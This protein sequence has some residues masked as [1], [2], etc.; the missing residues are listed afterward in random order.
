MKR[1]LISAVALILCATMFLFCGCKPKSNDETTVPP[2]TDAAIDN[3]I[4]DDTEP[5]ADDTTQSAQP[6]QP[7]RPAQQVLPTRP[8]SKKP[9]ATKKDPSASV[10]KPASGTSKPNTTVPPVKKD[11]WKKDGTYT[12]SKDISRGEYYIVPGIGGN[13]RV[14]ITNGDEKRVFYPLPYGI[15]VTIDNGYTLEIKNGQFIAANKVTPMT[16]SNGEYAPGAYR[17][18]EDIPAGEYVIGDFKNGCDFYILHSTDFTKKNNVADEYA[19]DFPVYIKLNKGDRIVFRKDTKVRAKTNEGRDKDG[20][21]KPGTYTIGGNQDIKPGKYVLVPTG[22]KNGYAHATHTNYITY[23]GSGKNLD[24][25]KEYIIELKS[26][27]YIIFE[28]FKLIEYVEPKPTEPSSE[29]SSETSS[30]SSSET[31]S[32][33]DS[34]KEKDK[35]NDADTP[36]NN[37]AGDNNVGDNK[38]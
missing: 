29:A 26:G 19:V 8:A 7:A 12:C 9:V 33:S 30:E 5:A 16:S 1:K 36:K 6:A 11:E 4:G 25:K 28:G 10:N 23:L 38:N 2:D 20:S 34:D 15:F 3:I 35:G 18:G 13:C 21:Y 37:E 17:I 32:E 14:T 24:I 27:E 22:E 31:S